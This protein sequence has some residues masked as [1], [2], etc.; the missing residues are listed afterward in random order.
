MTPKLG[1]C[2]HHLCIRTIFSTTTDT[3]NG[4]RSKATVASKEMK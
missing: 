2:P 1:C 3:T 4:R